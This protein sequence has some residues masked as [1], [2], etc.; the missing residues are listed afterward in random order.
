MPSAPFKISGLPLTTDQELSTPLT[1]S[2]P[3]NFFD[4]PNNVCHWRC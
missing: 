4:T 3:E 2:H 1:P